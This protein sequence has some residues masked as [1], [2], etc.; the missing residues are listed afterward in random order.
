MKCYTGTWRMRWA[1]HAAH[2]G[3]MRSS[4]KILVGK[5]ERKRP[6]ERL[7]RSWGIILEWV[8]RK[9][10]GKVWIGFIRLR[11]LGQWWTFVNT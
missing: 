9:W 5:P 3:D 1:G 2:L 8:L 10:G 11:I 4:Y 7:E 6:L